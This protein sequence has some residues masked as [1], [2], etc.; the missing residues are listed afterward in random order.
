MRVGRRARGGPQSECRHAG[1]RTQV[2]PQRLPIC[3]HFNIRSL[4]FRVLARP[5]MRRRARVRVRRESA[6]VADLISH[7]TCGLYV[8][9]SSIGAACNAPTRE[10]AW[11]F[12]FCPQ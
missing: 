6:A 2:N 1:R 8:L 12:L 9:F 7:L 4:R 5:T 11:R 10:F 3:V